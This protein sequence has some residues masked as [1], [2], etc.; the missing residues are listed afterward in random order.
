M[1]IDIDK[2]PA[3]L[4][5]KCQRFINTYIASEKVDMKGR[6]VKLS[7]EAILD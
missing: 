4:K 6:V 1:D 7:T 5:V 2:I 3:L